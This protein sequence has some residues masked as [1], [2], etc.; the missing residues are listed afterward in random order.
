ML[1]SKKLPLLKKRKQ[2]NRTCTD[3]KFFKNNRKK[4]WD[5]SRLIC[6]N[7]V[8]LF[9]NHIKMIDF[10]LRKCTSKYRRVSRKEY[11]KKLKEQDNRVKSRTKLYRKMIKRYSTKRIY[12]NFWYVSRMKKFCL[13]KNRRQKNTY[14]CF[15]HKKI[16]FSRKS[17][18]SRMGKGKGTLKNWY[19]KFTSGKSLFF[20]RRWKT[21]ATLNAF[22]VLKQYIPGRTIISMPYIRLKRSNNPSPAFFV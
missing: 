18:N 6:L 5:F 10:F 11:Y 7:Y 14:L 17:L 12:G 16:P 20:L 1:F 19:I 13:Q 9:L 8:R 15:N 21:I 3:F 2:K 22:R 4:K